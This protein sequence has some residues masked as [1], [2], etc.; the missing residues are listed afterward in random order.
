M[1]TIEKM[2]HNDNG[3]VSI[4]ADGR[5]YSAWPPVANKVKQFKEGDSVN[6]DYK[7]VNKG[8]RTYYNITGI[9]N[10]SGSNGGSASVGGPAPV[11]GSKSDT[12]LMMMVRYALDAMPQGSAKSP[13]EAVDLVHE[14]TGLM[15]DK[16]SGKAEAKPVSL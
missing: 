11:A 12:N 6:I 8:D 15:R 14:L 10:G 13:R 16:L 5:K 9:S 1:A 2:Y 3:S 4:T 7:E